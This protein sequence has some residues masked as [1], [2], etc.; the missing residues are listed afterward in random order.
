VYYVH[1]TGEE[2]ILLSYIGTR[3][4][5]TFSPGG[6]PFLQLNLASTCVSVTLDTE[7]CMYTGSI[8]GENRRKLGNGDRG[9]KQIRPKIG[10]HRVIATSRS[11][12]CL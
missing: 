6:C 9:N 8:C 7:T 3:S 10:Y 12:L 11:D 4:Y 5:R 2:R 1:E